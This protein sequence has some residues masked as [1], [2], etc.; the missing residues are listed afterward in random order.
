M[1]SLL[2][3][4]YRF[5]DHSA[6]IEASF[7]SGSHTSTLFGENLLRWQIIPGNKYN[8]FLHLGS[9]MSINIF[10]F[11]RLWLTS[12]H[13]ITFLEKGKLVHL[14]W[15]LYL[16]SLRLAF[17]QSAELLYC[18]ILV[19]S[20]LNHGIKISK[21]MQNTLGS[22]W[23]SSSIFLWNILLVGTTQNRS[24]MCCTCQRDKRM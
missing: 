10:N 4:S 14:I 17:L 7:H 8:S 2:A 13:D 24:L 5:H 11:L 12:S 23:N 6:F 3:L 21:V 22:L 18:F 20:S 15:H 16:L 9:V 1:T 19:S